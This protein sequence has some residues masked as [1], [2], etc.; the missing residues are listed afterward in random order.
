MDREE[1]CEMTGGER[2]HLASNSEQSSSFPN[3]AVVYPL[4]VLVDEHVELPVVVPF[5]QGDGRTSSVSDLGEAAVR[6]RT[7]PLD[8]VVIC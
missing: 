7:D 4:Q 3:S 5:S 1:G 2:S 8:Q 6:R